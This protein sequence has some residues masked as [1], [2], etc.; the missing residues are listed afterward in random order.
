MFRIPARKQ[1]SKQEWPTSKP[2]SEFP[3]S[4]TPVPDQEIL[5]LKRNGRIRARIPGG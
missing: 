3:N 5:F 4:D 1:F 2:G